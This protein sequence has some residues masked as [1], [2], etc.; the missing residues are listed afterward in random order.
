MNGRTA[1]H[2]EHS[3]DFQTFQGR[4]VIG[5]SICSVNPKGMYNLFEVTTPEEFR[6]HLIQL[7]LTATMN[8]KVKLQREML[9]VM[10]MFQTMKKAYA[11]IIQVFRY[12]LAHTP[13]R[14]SD[15]CKGIAIQCI[16]L[17]RTSMKKV[18]VYKRCEAP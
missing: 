6:L 14:T 8:D 3:S 17:N 16:P 5:G 12:R 15:D 2:K 10:T 18:H 9:F 1:C 4:E 11:S 7:L 13:C